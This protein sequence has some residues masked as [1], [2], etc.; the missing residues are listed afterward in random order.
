[1]YLTTIGNTEGGRQELLLFHGFLGNIFTL[2][3]PIWWGLEAS[4]AYKALINMFLPMMHV[5]T[6]LGAIFLPVLVE[7][8]GLPNFRHLVLLFSIFVVLITVIYWVLLGVFSEV[9]IRFLYTG[10]YLEYVD[11]LWLT[12]IIPIMGAFSSFWL[13]PA[14][15]GTTG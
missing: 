5:T 13:R 10:K 6:A 8:R 2:F 15:N 3:L 9:I 7:K 14:G 1:M 12:G 11:L 4:A